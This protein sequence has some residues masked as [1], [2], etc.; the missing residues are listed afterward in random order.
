MLFDT[1]VRFFTP[2]SRSASIRSNGLPDRPK[3][4]TAIVIPSLTTSRS[5]SAIEPVMILLDIYF[6]S[7]RVADTR[8]PTLWKQGPEQ[9][10]AGAR[11]LL[12]TL[13]VLMGIELAP[14]NRDDQNVWAA[15]GVRFSPGHRVS[16]Q[17]G[18]ISVVAELKVVGEARFQWR[19]GGELH[20]QLGIGAKI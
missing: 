17:A 18:Q 19:L 8:M 10:F 3:P 13:D 14:S 12:R 2:V 11:F 16:N 15:P 9:R 4:P 5:R 6:P 7:P 1:T 20:L